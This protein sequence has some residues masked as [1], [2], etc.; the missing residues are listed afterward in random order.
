MRSRIV[1]TEK[2]D[3]LLFTNAGNFYEGSVDDYTLTDKT[4]EKYRNL[5]L[6]NAMVNSGMIETLGYGI[7]KMYVEQKR[8]FFPMPNM[9]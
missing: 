2:V 3:E 4:P 6:A 1:L 9:I 8:R 5:F 7:K